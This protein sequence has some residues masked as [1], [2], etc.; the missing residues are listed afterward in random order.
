MSGIGDVLWTTPLLA[1]LR[2]AYP[3]AYIAYVVRTASSFVLENNPDVDEIIRFE[4]ESIRYQL[5]FLRRLR[6]KRFDLSIDLICSPATAIQSV[7]SG[8][9]VR[10]GYDFRVR[11]RLYTHRLS[12]REANHGHEV[13]FN[14]FALR[15]LGIQERTRS[16]VWRVSDA[17][18]ARAEEQWAELGLE[19]GSPV[20]ALVP[21][22]GYPSKKWPRTHWQAVVRD[23]RLDGLRFLVFWGNESEYHDAQAIAASGAHVRVAPPGSLRE[24]AALMDRCA[25]LLG[26]DSGPS[27]VGTALGLPSALFYGPSDPKSQG[28]WS[29]RAEVLRIPDVETRCCRRLDCPEPVCMTEIPP[30][31]AAEAVERALQRGRAEGAW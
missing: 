18:R 14:L 16:L 10:V 12:A 6:K 11:E 8:A 1:N 15:A 28:P 2:L 21:T 17:E 25:A 7:A 26:N 31:H 9:C 30:A 20:V 5:G 23:P 29:D 3:E 19:G 27:H 24:A 4:D 13:E 22:G